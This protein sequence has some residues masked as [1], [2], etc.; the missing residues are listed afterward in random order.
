MQ[1]KKNSFEELAA[2]KGHLKPNA[3]N[4]IDS[5][6]GRYA[7][8]SESYPAPIEHAG[9]V[10]PSVLHA[11]QASKTNDRARHAMILLIDDPHEVKKFSWEEKVA[12]QWIRKKLRLRLEMRRQQFPYG[13][14]LAQQL[15]D[16]G[17][18]KIYFHNR[19]L[20]RYWGVTRRKNGPYKGDNHDGIILMQVRDELNFRSK[21][22]DAY[23]ECMANPE[24]ANL[25]QAALALNAFG[26]LGI[27]FAHI[28]DNKTAFD[29]SDVVP[30]ALVLD[31][32]VEFT[33]GTY[34]R[35]PVVLTMTQLVL[36]AFSEHLKR[37]LA[38]GTL[39]IQGNNGLSVVPPPTEKERALHVSDTIIKMLTAMGVTR[40]NGE[41]TQCHTLE[42][43]NSCTQLPCWYIDPS[44]PMHFHVRYMPTDPQRAMCTVVLERKEGNA[45]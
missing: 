25:S 24:N 3:E 36:G 12:W 34:S 37:G 38:D 11:F 40:Y 27:P 42:E 9:T 20:D 16:T 32:R 22:H 41:P 35:P 1:H 31:D 28:F 5:F 33:I 21:L 44:D 30:R 14:T 23:F 17:E 10:F 15:I 43:F 19:F 39:S 7:F 45:E 29:N 2:L 8:L 13:S 4:V 18:A 6:T 26:V